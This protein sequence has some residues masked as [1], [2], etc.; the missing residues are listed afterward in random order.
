MTPALS[1]LDCP[2]LGEVTEC[3]G[4]DTKPVDTDLT[5]WDPA[6]TLED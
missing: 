4:L 3:K 2:S 1:A 5:H 6:W